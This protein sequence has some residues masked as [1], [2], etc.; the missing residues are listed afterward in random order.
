MRGIGVVHSTINL[1]FITFSYNTC[2]RV[3]EQFETEETDDLM[4]LVT[5]A[6]EY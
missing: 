4:S 6:I 3:N 1:V 5:P 2:F